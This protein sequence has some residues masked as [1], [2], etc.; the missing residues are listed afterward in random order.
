MPHRGSLNTPAQIPTILRFMAEEREADLDE[1]CAA[2]SA[3]SERI[4]G[5]FA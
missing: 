2:I 4:F 1:L 3:N 5:P